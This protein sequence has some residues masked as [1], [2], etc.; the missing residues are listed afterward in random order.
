MLYD[1]LEACRLVERVDWQSSIIKVFPKQQRAGSATQRFIEFG[2]THN[3]H[4]T[5]NVVLFKN[6]PA[7]LLPHAW[8]IL[9]DVCRGKEL[10]PDRVTL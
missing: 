5:I 8:A 6:S 2:V 4:M 3:A 9:R 7:H 10:F 1:W